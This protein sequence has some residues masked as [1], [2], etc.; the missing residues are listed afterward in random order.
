MRRRTSLSFSTSASANSLPVVYL[1]TVTYMSPPSDRSCECLNSAAADLRQPGQRRGQ[2]VRSRVRPGV[3]AGPPAGD[4]RLP[5]ELLPPQQRVPPRWVLGRDDDRPAL[6]PRQPEAEDVRSGSER[7]DHAAVCD[8]DGLAVEVAEGAACRGRE[9]L[10][11]FA[12]VRMR[13]ERISL[14]DPRRVALA[15]RRQLLRL[16]VREHLLVLAPAKVKRIHRRKPYP[17]RGSSACRPGTMKP[18]WVASPRSPSSSSSAS[19]SRR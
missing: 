8:H 12:Q 9:G 13:R 1:R 17:D 5:L 18:A 15:P 16:Q 4:E 14:H 10:D 6:L 7:H 19:P 2:R 3:D 11:P